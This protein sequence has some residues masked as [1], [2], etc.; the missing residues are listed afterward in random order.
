MLIISIRD[1]GI[2]GWMSF[3]EIDVKGFIE[4]YNSLISKDPIIVQEV[5]KEG[6]LKR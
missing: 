2:E 6:P 1:Y 5:G 4:G 3:C